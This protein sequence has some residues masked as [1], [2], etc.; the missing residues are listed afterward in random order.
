MSQNASEATLKVLVFKV[1]VTCSSHVF[2]V[3]GDQQILLG[4]K[5]QAL[6]R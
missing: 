2:I 3:R 4:E 5:T 6:Y 1:K